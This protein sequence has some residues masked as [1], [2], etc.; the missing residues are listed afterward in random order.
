MIHEQMTPW[1]VSL[2]DSRNGFWLAVSK[3]ESKSVERVSLTEL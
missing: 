1:K 3:S 2:K